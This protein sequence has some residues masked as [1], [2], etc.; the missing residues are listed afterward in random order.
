MNL[1]I[2]V[3]MDRNRVIGRNED[4][5][6]RLSA[7]L[8]K[9]KKVTM[10]KPIVMGRKTH[11]SIG[12]PLPGRENIILT[13]DPGYSSEGC[14]VI[15]SIDAILDYCHDHE[16]IMITGGAEIYR[17]LMDRV[18]RIY[19]TEVHAEVEGD[20]YFPTINMDEWELVEREDYQA[21]EK[22]EY[23]FSFLVL[24]RK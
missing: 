14:T 24:D 1:S 12:R 15:T 18:H 9:F 7:D 13:R 19:L 17:M 20:T 22:N 2:I 23:D 16:E 11:E 3:A 10:G 5:P 6:W 4:L 21:D 8:Q